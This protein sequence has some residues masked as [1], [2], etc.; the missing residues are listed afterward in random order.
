[1]EGERS[2]IF[3]SS[4]WTGR[5]KDGVRKERSER[6]KVEMTQRG[7]KMAPEKVRRRGLHCLPSVSILVLFYSLIE[8]FFCELNV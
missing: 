5:N 3:R 7:P 2:R 1:M 6:R 4:D 8:F